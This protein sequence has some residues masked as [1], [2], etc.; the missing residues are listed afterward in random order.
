LPQ[1]TEE[2]TTE[3][4]V[5]LNQAAGVRTCVADGENLRVEVGAGTYRFVVK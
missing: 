2:R 1:A 3:S 4:G 5:A